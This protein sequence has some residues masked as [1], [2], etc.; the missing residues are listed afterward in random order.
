M[1]EK[2]GWMIE[3]LG[4]GVGPHHRRYLVAVPDRRKT[5]AAL[6]IMLG[7]QIA[8][9]AATPATSRDLEIAGVS[10]GKILAV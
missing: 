5:V 10:P 2:G 1:T 4:S 9:S 8:V 7:T 6:H 3:I